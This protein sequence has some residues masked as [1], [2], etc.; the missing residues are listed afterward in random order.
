MRIVIG[1]K[2]IENNSADIFFRYNMSKVNISFDKIFDKIIESI[3]SIQ[4]NMIK[5]SNERLIN[6]THEADSYDNF[7]KLIE[8]QS[9]FVI[10]GWDGTKETEEAIKNETKATIRC[11]PE[12]TDSRGITCI[13]SGKP[14][15]HKVIFSKSY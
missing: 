12:N 3:D 4:D 7:K 1:L 6:N 10:A 13:Y 2:E 15:A 9:G 8:S 11:I 5:L 14:A